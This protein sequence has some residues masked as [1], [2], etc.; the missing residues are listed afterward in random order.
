[1]TDE[2]NEMAYLTDHYEELNISEVMERS[3]GTKIWVTGLVVSVSGS[4][5]VLADPTGKLDVHG[6]DSSYED[7]QPESTVRVL[8]TLTSEGHVD[9]DWIIPLNLHFKEFVQ[10]R[11]I[12]KRQRS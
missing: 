10:M 9:A 3:F 8:G 11:E 4:T 1:M 6:E 5:I 12:E 7:L 2:Y